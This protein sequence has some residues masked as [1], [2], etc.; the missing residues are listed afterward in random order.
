MRGS[1]R[2]RADANI[3]SMSRCTGSKL[4]LERRS[5]NRLNQANERASYYAGKCQEAARK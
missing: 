3:L 4:W 5:V 1:D 2:N